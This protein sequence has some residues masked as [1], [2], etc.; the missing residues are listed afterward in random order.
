MKSKLSGEGHGDARRVRVFYLFCRGGAGAENALDGFDP[1]ADGTVQVVVV[2]PDGKIL[3][4]GEFTTAL[5]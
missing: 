2:Q 5:P 1:N 3:I 4:G